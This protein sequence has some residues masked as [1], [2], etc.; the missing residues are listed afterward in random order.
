MDKRFTTA[1][2]ARFIRDCIGPRG[3]VQSAD[4]G[5]GDI[6]FTMYDAF[7]FKCGLDDRYGSFGLI[8]PVEAGGAIRSFLGRE[9][10]M[11]SDPQS[12]RE[13]LQLV[14]SYCRLRLPDKY[15]EVFDA[16]Y[17]PASE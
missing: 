1:E 8:L 13:S 9:I 12:I 2:L 6:V 5:S 16:A 15:L 7:G 17:P 4:S 11:N 14:D 10:S 3:R